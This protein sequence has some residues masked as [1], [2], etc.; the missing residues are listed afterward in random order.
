MNIISQLQLCLRQIAEKVQ[1]LYVNN[2]VLPGSTIAPRQLSWTDGLETI[3]LEPTGVSL[4]AELGTVTLNY[5]GLAGDNTDEG[6][7]FGINPDSAFGKSAIGKWEITATALIWRD[8]NNVITRQISSGRSAYV[9]EY[10]TNNAGVAVVAGVS[11]FTP[12]VGW[13]SCRYQLVAGGPGGGSG[14]R[15]A[16][17]TIRL[18]GTGAP[19]GNRSDGVLLASQVPGGNWTIRVGKGGNGGNAPI[20]DD[21][22][23]IKGDSG[24]ATDVSQGATLLAAAA[25][26]G[27]FVSAPS[28]WSGL[29]GTNAASLQPFS[30]GSNGLSS[31]PSASGGFSS[32]TIPA[33]NSIATLH[34]AVSGAGGGSLN[35]ANDPKSPGTGNAV[36]Q[37]GGAAAGAAGGGGSAPTGTVTGWGTGGAGSGAGFNGATGAPGGNG[38]AGVAILVFSF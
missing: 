6:L 29:G 20:T 21:T 28:F 14:R 26:T 7:Q 12:P 16:A 5:G 13:V 37:T 35:A 19:G 38:T 11:T 32:S 15:G 31:F 24:G 1:R 27:N 8:A 34:A 3:N 17:G 30:G 18:G 36:A 33:G 23:G 25:I 2:G 22:D 10:A 4:E 9:F